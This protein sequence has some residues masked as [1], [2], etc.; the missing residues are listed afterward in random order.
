MESLVSAGIC[1]A[2]ILSR[3]PVL[4]YRDVLAAFDVFLAAQPAAT[5]IIL[6]GHSQGA[7]HLSRL[8]IERRAALKGRL[9]A[10]YVVGWPLSVSADLPATGLP[11]C[12]PPDHAVWILG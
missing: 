8:L 11:P 1:F 7:L 6:A 9:V 3:E 4:A 2:L 5:P 10:A 12:N